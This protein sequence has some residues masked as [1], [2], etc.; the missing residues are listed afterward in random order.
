MKLS[1]NWELD[2]SSVMVFIV[3][4]PTITEQ[5]P[6]TI[7]FL[8]KNLQ[9]IRRELMKPQ[10]IVFKRSNNV[11]FIYN[12][13]PLPIKGNYQRIDGYF[14]ISNSM[15][16]DGIKG[17]SDNFRMELY[18]DKEYLMTILNRLITP[19]DESPEVYRNLI[20]KIDGVGFYKKE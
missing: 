11:D 19:E 17:A 2:T 6:S 13:V 12:E 15:F 5:Y 14:I 10:K 7:K 8:A 20:E 9:P 16:P 4:N 18:Y 3:Y 1:G